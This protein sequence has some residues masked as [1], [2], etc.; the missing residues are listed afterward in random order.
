MWLVK[1]E[2]FGWLLLLLMLVATHFVTI[3]FCLSACVW[4]TLKRFTSIHAIQFISIQ[5]L[6]VCWMWQKCTSAL[7]QHDF[8]HI[9]IHTCAHTKMVDFV[10]DRFYATIAVLVSPTTY[11]M[12]FR[13]WPLQC[14]CNFELC[15]NLLFTASRRDRDRKRN[16]RWLSDFQ[17]WKMHDVDI[18]PR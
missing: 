10:K 3:P 13:C 2:T 11:K 1:D 8:F 7:F 12:H 9:F 5:F 15:K 17:L 14:D 6:C 16:M 18:M 4:N